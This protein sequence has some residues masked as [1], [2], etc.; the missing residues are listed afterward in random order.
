MKIPSEQIDIKQIA[1]T[2]G[3]HPIVYILTKGGLHAFFT[4]DSGGQIISLGAAPHRGIAQWLCEQKDKSI[5]WNDD[6]IQKAEA[7]YANLQ[8]AEADQYLKLRNMMFAP[9]PLEPLE[10]VENLFIVYDTGSKIIGIMEKSDVVEGI[11]SCEIDRFC[12]I[13]HINLA[14]A[15]VIVEKHDIFAEIGDDNG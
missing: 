2:S 4:K 14:S 10:N 13:R 9:I 8:K 11:K 3:D 1:G 7:N 12:L 6:F 5:K 15:P